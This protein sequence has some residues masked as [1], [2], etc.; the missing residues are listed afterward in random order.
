MG[1]PPK[2]NLKKQKLLRLQIPPKVKKICLLEH[3]LFK[4]FTSD[5]DHP[6]YIPKLKL[7]SVNVLWNHPFNLNG[8]LARALIKELLEKNLISTVATHNRISLYTGESKKTQR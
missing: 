4:R 8:S 3:D 5:R 2:S 7:I 6:N 1:C